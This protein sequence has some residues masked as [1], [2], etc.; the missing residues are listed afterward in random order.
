MKRFPFG[1]GHL[2]KQFQEKCEA[3]FRPESRHLKKQFQEKCEAVFRPESRHLK[4]QFQEKCEAVFRPE[5]RHLKKQFQEKCEAV[6]RPESRHLKKQ[7]QEKCEAVFRPES[8]E[9]PYTP[10]AFSFERDLSRGTAAA[11]MIHVIQNTNQCAHMALSR[12]LLHL[13]E[14]GVEHGNRNQ[15][16]ASP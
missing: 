15:A 7:F 10:A 2:K 16:R 12:C 14:D 11:N 4:K 13:L 3:V 5:S 1:I 6:F 8:I 9:I